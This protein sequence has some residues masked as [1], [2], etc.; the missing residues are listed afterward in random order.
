M[1]RLGLGGEEGPAHRNYFSN[2]KTKWSQLARNLCGL[3]ITDDHKKKRFT[4]TINMPL[5]CSYY[6]YYYWATKHPNKRTRSYKG[7]RYTSI[8]PYIV[9]AH[10]LPIP[11]ITC[12]LLSHR[13][14]WTRHFRFQALFLR[15]FVLYMWLV[16]VRLSLFPCQ[17]LVCP[18]YHTKRNLSINQTV[19]TNKI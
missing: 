10:S 1:T 14:G 6:Y 5:Y 7:V 8:V 17:N 2:A 13:N 15:C 16:S 11:N 19:E 3:T 4:D 12:Q 9:N 18:K